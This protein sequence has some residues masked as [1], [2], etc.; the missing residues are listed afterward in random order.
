MWRF[1]TC[2]LPCLNSLNYCIV[3]PYRRDFPV[4]TILQL[5]P[6]MPAVTRTRKGDASMTQRWL[7][8]CLLCALVMPGRMRLR[9]LITSA[10]D[11]NGAVIPSKTGSKKAGTKVVE[12]VSTT[13]RL[14][15]PVFLAHL[16]RLVR[17]CYARKWKLRVQPACSRAIGISAASFATTSIRVCNTSTS[18]GA[19]P[20]RSPR[21]QP[22][23]DLTRWN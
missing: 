20:M 3:L 22:R 14:F 6:S 18:A 10:Q 21:A 13:S 7:I 12:V 4:C 8:C 2:A 23:S 15:K 5:V 9:E 16:Q 11:K 1:V 17:S 19:A